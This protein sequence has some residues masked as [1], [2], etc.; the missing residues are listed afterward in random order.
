MKRIF[1]ATFLASLSIAISMAIINVISM[2]LT[3]DFSRYAIVVASMMVI[4]AA[5]VGV[6]GILV[7][8][9]PLHIILKRHKVRS[10]LPYILI[11]FSTA[12]GFVFLL[13]PFGN[14]RL[15]DLFQQASIIGAIGSIS[16]SVFWY[17]TVK[18]D[19]PNQQRLGDA[20]QTAR[21]R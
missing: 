16:A 9:V 20:K 17:V 10:V 15:I 14:D 3:D 5:N 2:F 7:I 11:G 1:F 8:G 21:Q 18:L 13:K 19:K 6:I 4:V 12:F